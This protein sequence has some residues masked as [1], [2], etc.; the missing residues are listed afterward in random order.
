MQ[1]RKHRDHVS[2]SLECTPAFNTILH[3]NIHEKDKKITVHSN[4]KSKDFCYII[5][6]GIHQVG[7]IL[8]V[9]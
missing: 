6:R 5:I 9:D 1:Q 4:S 2:L 7:T 3:L 8:N